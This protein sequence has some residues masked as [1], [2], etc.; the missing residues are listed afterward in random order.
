MKK[1]TLILLTVVLGLTVALN[2]TIAQGLL[3]PIWMKSKFASNG[4]KTEGWGV[5]VDNNG[6]VYWPVSSDSTGQ[7]LDIFCYKFNSNGTPLWTTPFFFGGAG[8]QHAFVCN[9]KDT[10][11][12]IGGRYCAF[13]GFS[14]DMQLLK[15][16]KSNGALIWSKTKDFGNNGY[17]EID[18]LEVMNDGIYCGGWAQ[19]L[20]MGPYQIDLG[21]WKVDFNGN[22]LWTNYFGK[23]TTA[24]HQ[25][26]HFV[27]DANYIYGAGEWD[28]KGIANINNGYS[29]LG[30]FSRA[31]GSY[32]DST[33]FGFQSNAFGDIENALGMTT[34]GTYLYITGYTTPFSAN[35][36]QIFVAKYD[37]NMNQLWFQNWGG[38]NTE[39]ARGIAVSNGM[40]Y[41]AGLT[42]SPGYNPGGNVDAALLVYD[43]AGTF[44]T[45]KTWGDTLDEAFRDIAI[46]GNAIYLSGS[47]GNDLAGADSDSGFVMK[48]DMAS[49]WAS[50]NNNNN[51][52]ETL[53]V[54][55]NPFSLQTTVRSDNLLTNATLTVINCFGQTVV[56]IKNISGQTITFS[57]DNLPSGLY[58][59]HLTQDNQEIAIKK[60]IVTD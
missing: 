6:N 23:T 26:G 27:I 51:R 3:T 42:T 41:I 57:R 32:V 24:E 55:P 39:S 20:Q 2:Q 59:I 15:I 10:A 4:G 48:V 47:S 9:A 17:D 38:S 11:L 52:L 37:K 60:I 7:A 46:S 34:D 49:T 28:G 40:I 16:N 56:Q 8:T 18:G 30:K 35:N 21:L 53:Q 19:A 5:D 58:F 25:D 31:D 33:L 1:H 36:W 12:Y 50:V 43:T 14:C 45:Y 29:F 22:T 54:Y 44:L 13:S